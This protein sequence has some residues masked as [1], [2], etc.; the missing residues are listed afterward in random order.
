MA[1]M[2]LAEKLTSSIQNKDY[3]VGIFLDLKKAFDTIS[4]DILLEKMERYG[5]RG[6]G[7]S[8]IKSYIEN[9]QQYVEIDEYKS[10][11]KDQY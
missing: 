9:R 8:W 6:I 4:F 10:P 11:C 1:L 7:L 2:E 5:I 3:A